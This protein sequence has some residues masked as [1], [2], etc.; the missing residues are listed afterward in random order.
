[1]TFS[2]AGLNSCHSDWCSDSTVGAK[3]CICRAT[4]INMVFYKELSYRFIPLPFCSLSVTAS[5]VKLCKNYGLYWTTVF[6]M[7]AYDQLLWV[8]CCEFQFQD[9]CACLLKTGLRLDHLKTLLE[10][11]VKS[12]LVTLSVVLDQITNMRS[13]LVWSFGLI[14]IVWLVVMILSDGKRLMW[15][16]FWQSSTY[17]DV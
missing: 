11:F 16:C 5:N 9:Q 6:Y 12:K 8:L 2:K 13:S 14:L 10:N 3:L 15:H 17:F 7:L 4:G 1:V